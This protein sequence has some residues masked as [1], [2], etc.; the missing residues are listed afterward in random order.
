VQVFGALIVVALA[1]LLI[2][3]VVSANDTA[4][5]KRQVVST[6]DSSARLTSTDDSRRFAWWHEGVDIW[7]RS[8]LIGK[9]GGAFDAYHVDKPGDE[10]DHVHSM[11]LEILLETGIVGALLLLAATI[12]FLRVLRRGRRTTERALG[13]ALAALLLTQ[14][15]IDWTLS[16]PQVIVLLAL[17][18]P[19]AMQSPPDPDEQAAAEPLEPVWWQLSMLVSLA[20]ATMVAFVP[21]LAALL[22]DQAATKFDAHQPNKAAS[23]AEQS[24][25]LVPSFETLQVQVIS[26]QSAGHEQAAAAVLRAH[27]QV[28][29]HS[30]SGLTF[31]QD[32]LKDD[33]KLGPKIERDIARLQ[34]EQS[35]PV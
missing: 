9:G 3:L 14:A 2:T 30:L 10:A 11:P 29:S 16:V 17:A 21:M 6:N 22:A 5:P 8:P 24:L 28:W 23:L 32:L 12:T 31:A 15:L 18:G 33:P 20:A 19:L 4:L 1:A 7:Q 26:L 27:E 35:Q 25:Q 34:R 13:G